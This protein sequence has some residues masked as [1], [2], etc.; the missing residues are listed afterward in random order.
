VSLFKT[1]A[2]DLSPGVVTVLPELAAM[3][4]EQEPN[5]SFEAHRFAEDP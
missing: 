5:L 4:L 1:T 2:A 3:H